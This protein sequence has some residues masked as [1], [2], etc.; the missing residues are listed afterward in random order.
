MDKNNNKTKIIIAVISAIS[1]IVVALIQF[2]PWNNSSKKQKN[3]NV[4]YSIAG[5]VVDESTNNSIGQAEISI[6]GRN[7]EY[8][9][10]QNGNFRILFKDSVDHVRLRV[11]KD[12]FLPFDKSFDLPNENIIIQLTKSHHE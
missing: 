8:F 7:E 6:V 1:L 10:E 5:T 2:R 4:I 11:T 9:T 3:N 12:H